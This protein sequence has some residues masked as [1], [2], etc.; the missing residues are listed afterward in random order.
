M[1]MPKVMEK[2]FILMVNII[3]GIFYMVN[4]MEKANYFIKMEKYNMM[5]IGLMIFLKV[6]EKEF[7]KMV[8]IT[9]ENGKMIMLMEKELYIIKMGK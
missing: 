2:F 3:K 5:V 6:M 1:I 8:N 7:L 4:V 9:K